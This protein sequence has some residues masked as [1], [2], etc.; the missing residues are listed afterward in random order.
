M[1]SHSGR[2]SR[3]DLEPLRQP[4]TAW[5]REVSSRPTTELLVSGPSC[6]PNAWARLWRANATSNLPRTCRAL[7]ASARCW[8]TR[9]RDLAEYV[10]DESVRFPNAEAAMTPWLRGQL[11]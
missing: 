6:P 1:R 3:T 5:E 4:H 2:R 11:L 9:S 8:A 7:A 10:D